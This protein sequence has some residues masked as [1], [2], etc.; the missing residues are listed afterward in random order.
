MARWAK[1]VFA[2]R[3]DLGGEVHAHG[4]ISFAQDF[5]P[6]AFQPTLNAPLQITDSKSSRQNANI[7]PADPGDWGIHPSCLA[8][9]GSRTASSLYASFPQI[10]NSEIEVD[11]E[12]AIT[13]HPNTVRLQPNPALPTC[14]SERR[15]GTG[16]SA[17]VGEHRIVR[18]SLQ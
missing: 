9:S 16:P 13:T 3:D 18:G 1:K 15:T 11:L 17:R 14:A 6:R 12:T 8:H 5:L 4:R 2:K 7:D 10:H